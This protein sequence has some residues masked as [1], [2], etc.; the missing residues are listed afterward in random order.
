MPPWPVCAVQRNGPD[1]PLRLPAHLPPGAVR[2]DGHQQGQLR[3]GAH[4]RVV[5]RRPPP[6]WRPPLR[7]NPLPATAVAPTIVLPFTAVFPPHLSCRNQPLLKAPPIIATVPGS[8]PPTFAVPTTTMPLTTVTIPPSPRHPFLP[9]LRPS[10]VVRR[11]GASVSAR[12]SHRRLRPLR[13]HPAA[14]VLLWP[15]DGRSPVRHGCA[16]GEVATRAGR[17]RPHLGAVRGGA[18]ATRDPHG[19]RGRKARRGS[20][21][22]CNSRRRRCSP[23]R[24][25]DWRSW[26]CW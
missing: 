20:G 10:A 6:P 17:C 15:G 18:S 22:R 8:P 19:Q 21:G 12:V 4:P 25:R 16:A 23:D 3:P 7:R 13:A 9:D 14:A 5:L 1:S 26:R 24:R 11:A 2:R